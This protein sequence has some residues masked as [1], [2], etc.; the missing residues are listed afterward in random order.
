[1]IV[2]G[3]ELPEKIPEAFELNLLEIK[4]LHPNIPYKMWSGRDVRELIK[5]DFD[6]SVL[7]SYD[8]LTPYAYKCDLARLCILY[9]EGGLYI[10][11]G[12]RLFREFKV[13]SKIE[14]CAFRDLYQETGSFMIQNGLVYAQKGRPELLNAIN[15]IVQNCRDHYYGL[16]SLY[17]TGPVQLGRSVALVAASLGSEGAG[18]QWIGDCRSVTPSQDNKNMIYVDP[19]GNLVALRAKVRAGELSH[20]GLM[21]GNNYNESWQRRQAYGERWPAW[22]HD[23]QQIQLTG[24]G[25]RTPDGI[26]VVEKK[27]GRFTY[28]PYIGL[29]PGSYE[30]RVT[31][32]EGT[33]F[34]NMRVGICSRADSDN[35]FKG[36]FDNVHGKLNKI[37]AFF[38]IDH[39][40]SGVEIRLY[41]MGWLEGFIEKIEIVPA[42][43]IGDDKLRCVYNIFK[44]RGQNII[45]RMRLNK[46]E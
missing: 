18:A 1:M 42:D 25:R 11:L 21:G 20:M 33:K 8:T 15:W 28:G 17:P 38:S 41:N 36:N 14:F 26:T 12:V 44:M 46:R 27:K 2:D 39:F 9:V 19:F 32:K 45:S 6:Q 43:D 24:G 40:Y 13:P 22:K 35:L 23:D 34:H 30:I 7:D 10:D 3:G 4:K 29:S 31:F 16:N 37:R 5:N